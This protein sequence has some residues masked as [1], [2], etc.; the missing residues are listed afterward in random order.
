MKSIGYF[1]GAVLLAFVF[2]STSLQAVPVTFQV[3]MSYLID[4][5]RFDP[6]T[7]FVDVAGSFNG[8]GSD[9]LIPL[10]DQNAD[11]IYEVT[12]N[13]FVVGQEIQYKFRINGLWDGTEEF[14][15]GGA[16]RV[17]TVQDSNNAI[18]VWYNDE[19][20][21]DP[22]APLE[23][24]FTVTNATLFSKGIVLFESTSTGP[25]QQWEWTFEGGDPER[26]TDDLAT[27]FYEEPGQ[28]DV[29]L[30]VRGNGMADT[31][32]LPDY[33]TVEPRD[34][35]NVHWWNGRVFYEIFVRSFYD[36][37][38]DGIGDFQGLIQQLDYLNDGDPSTTDD[39]GI[40]GIWLMPIHPSP[41]YHGYDVVDYRSINPD[42]GTM[43]DFKTFLDA[44]HQRGIRVILDYVMN[45]SSSQHPWFLK[46]AQGDPHFRNFYVW[47]DT[48]PDY[49]GPWG[50]DVWHASN[51]EYYYGVFWSGMP[52][53]NYRYAPV[54]DSM[55]AIA[56]YWLDEVG[57]DGFRLDTI[58]HL[59]ENGPDQEHQ[60]ETLAFLEDWRDHIKSVK[61]DAFAV[62]EVWSS[63]S[64][65]LPYVTG[66]R[67]DYCF[68][69]D[70]AGGLLSSAGFGT[71]EPVAFE[72][73]KAYD[74]YPHLQYGVFAAN[75]DQNRIMS[76]LGEDPERAKLVASMYLL[77]PGIPYM[78]YGEEIGMTGTKPDPNIRTPMQWTDGPQAGFTTGTPWIPIPSTHSTYNIE[79]QSASATSILNRYREL[80]QLRNRKPAL[81]HG[82]YEP[83]A[84]V[85]TNGVYAFLREQDEDRFVIVL[86]LQ[87]QA[88]EDL[89]L[90]T[91]SSTLPSGT[92]E[93]TDLLRDS[94]LTVEID[95]F[96]LIRF[97]DLAPYG[98]HVIR[99][100][101]LVSTGAATPP[102]SEL[103]L[104]AFPNPGAG[105]IQLQYVL[106]EAGPV[107]LTVFDATGREVEPLIRE[108]QPA[109]FFTRQWN[110]AA[111]PAGVYIVRLTSPSGMRS[112]QIIIRD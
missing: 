106:P 98:F 9:P 11:S 109:G 21:E 66:D 84:P 4:Q 17:Y 104:H 87:N 1:L 77:L 92:Y 35:D 61:P 93:A 65:I 105:L 89:Q 101:E 76:V 15:G 8:W 64:N 47:S 34:W 46:A 57:V 22:N 37:D 74:I 45:H 29:Q 42:Y 24:R 3:N 103:R 80:I 13:G 96:R 99:L 72:M 48:L 44:A 43:A 79:T 55:F 23:A 108:W 63:S 111:L 52:D 26:F 20:P 91:L 31:L 102:R 12:L 50:Q 73:Q 67:L 56:G 25:V 95:A 83:I 27:V 40:T 82:H 68:D 94:S 112:E 41:S 90:Y 110:A 18:L 86:N 28:Y 38:G 5:G 60:P 49:Q 16:N 71:F 7:D 78:Y 6:A 75:H 107:Q 70:L 81:Q 53:L 30:I 10:A 97:G 36:S 59:F 58:K 54:Q 14:P 32:L 88:V 2:S 19:E 62:G 33:I 39:L 85:F 69:F 100:D 51:D